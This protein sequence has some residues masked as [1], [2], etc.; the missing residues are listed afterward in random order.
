MYYAA[1]DEGH[2]KGGLALFYF[3]THWSE[4]LEKQIMQDQDFLIQ[5]L[6]LIK[7]WS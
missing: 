5:V 7:L 4:V 6:G 3:L 1:N 2:T